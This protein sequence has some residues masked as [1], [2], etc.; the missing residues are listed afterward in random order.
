M[1]LLA[2]ALCTLLIGVSASAQSNPGT[3]TGALSDTAKT[4]VAGASIQ[5]KNV[6]TGAVYKA[7]S[8]RMGDYTLAQLPPGKYELSAYRPGMFW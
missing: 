7:V 8:G 2:I 6:E 3:M 4:P 5:V 1:R